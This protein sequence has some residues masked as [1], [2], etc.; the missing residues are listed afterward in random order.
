MRGL[1]ALEYWDLPSPSAPLVAL[2]DG[3]DLELCRYSNTKE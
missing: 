2:G 3:L 1:K